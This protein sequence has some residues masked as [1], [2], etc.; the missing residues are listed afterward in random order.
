MGTR[1]KSVVAL[2]LTLSAGLVDIL[3]F[4]TF[5]ST[6]TAHMTGV[7]VHLG[8]FVA[9]KKTFDVAVLIGV[10]LAFLLGSVIGRT[11]VEL[12]VHQK[13]RSAASLALFL[14][15]ATIFIVASVGGDHANVLMSLL[16]A[17]AMGLQTAALTRVGP[18]TVHTTFVTGMLNKLAQLLSQSLI[19]HCRTT[20]SAKTTRQISRQAVFLASIWFAYFLGAA[21]GGLM[22]P[23]WKAHSLFVP[24]TIVLATAIIDQVNPLSIEEERDQSER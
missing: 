21:A 1:L 5:Y 12:A 7:T 6:F 23:R 10:L 16:L 9:D 18:L 8:Q 24:A 4:L 11:V 13:L 20:R 15:A 14:E 2:L 17:A 19:L 3:G 22:D